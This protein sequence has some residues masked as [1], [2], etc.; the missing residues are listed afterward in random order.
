MHTIFHYGGVAAAVIS[1]AS[2]CRITAAPTPKEPCI[3]VSAEANVPL[4]N[5]DG[6]IGTA[7]VFQSVGT[8]RG[9]LSSVVTFSSASTAATEEPRRLTVTHTF[10]SADRSR[11]GTLT[12]KGRAACEPPGSGPIVCRVDQLLEIIAANGIFAPAGVSLRDT[13]AID[14]SAFHL[15]FSIRGRLCGDAFK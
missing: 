7:P 15:T 9:K 6:S 1:L 14:F 5:V 10:V 3:D 13:S 8:I 2:A 4:V 11:A 12:M